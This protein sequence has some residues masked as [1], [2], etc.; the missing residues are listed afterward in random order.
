[1]NLERRVIRLFDKFPF[2]YSLYEKMGLKDIR[3]GTN[4]LRKEIKRRGGIVQF[5][6]FKMMLDGSSYMDL[7]LYKQFSQTGIYE[8]ETAL[9]IMNSL[10]P[11]DVFVDIGANSGYYT[12]L[13]SRIVANRVTFIL[14]NPILI[15]ITDLCKIL[16][17]TL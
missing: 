11:G 10:S 9:Y 17:S 13:T 3:N 7:S 5:Q 8:K 16:C 15:H 1:M 12:L 6:D 14:L 2:L 4:H